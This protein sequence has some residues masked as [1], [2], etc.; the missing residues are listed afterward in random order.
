[1]STLQQIFQQKCPVQVLNDCSRVE[2]V[3]YGIYSRLHI[4][5]KH[6]SIEPMMNLMVLNSTLQL[7]Q[8]TQLMN[9]QKKENKDHV[10]LLQHIDEV[11]NVQKLSVSRVRHG[12]RVTIKV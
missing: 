9:Q 12:F 8:T 11:H 3:I 2:N 4:K 7:T 6:N 10:G 1:M 5:N